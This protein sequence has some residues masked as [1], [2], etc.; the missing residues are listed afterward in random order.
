MGEG[1]QKRKKWAPYLNKKPE[2]SYEKDCDTFA[3]NRE[4]KV[5]MLKVTEALRRAGL[6]HSLLN[7]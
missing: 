7:C 5:P 1:V 6:H 4:M 3:P 2:L